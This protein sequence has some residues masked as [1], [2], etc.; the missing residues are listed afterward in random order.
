MKLLP[1]LVIASAIW[2]T[3]DQQGRHAFEKK[4]YRQAAERFADPMWKG[5]AFFRAG[6]FE[7]AQAVFAGLDSAEAHYNRAN[8]LVMLGKYQDAIASYD[9]ALERRPGWTAAEENRAIA[10]ARAERMK[11]EGG[12]MGQQEIG[13][14]EIVFDKKKP[15]GQ[16]TEITTEQ[17]ADSTS[18]QALWLRRVQTRP[19]DF[20]KAKFA[21]QQMLEKDTNE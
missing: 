5:V 4:D 18:M 17:A 7:Q 15:G 20:L 12:E 13:A 21:Y 6:E 8:C 19:A 1:F 10:T 3:A 9:R 16:E 11:Q 2:F 14:D